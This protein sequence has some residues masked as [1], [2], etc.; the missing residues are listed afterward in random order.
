MRVATLRPG[1]D[2]TH[3]MT[4]EDIEH[5]DAHIG[6][7]ARGDA[8]EALW[9]LQQTLQVEGSLTPHKLHELVMLGDKAPGWMYSRWCVEQAYRWM[10]V[11]RDP[12]TDDAVIH[13]MVAAHAERSE[14][15][16]HD[17]TLFRE[18]GTLIAATDWLCEELAVFDYGGLLDFLD[19]KADASLV[20]RCDQIR[21]WAETRMNGY[22]LEDANG[23]ALRVRDLSTGAP[24][25]VMNIGALTDRGPDCPVIGRVVPVAS[26]PGLMFASR[27]VSVDL[28]TA[29]AVA[30]ASTH[31]DSA[32]WITCIDEGRADGRLE[33][34]FSCRN[35][36]L[37]SSDIVPMSSLREGQEERAGSA[38]WAAGGALGPGAERDPGQRRDGGG[39]RIHRHH[40]EWGPWG[41]HGCPACGGGDS[42]PAGLRGPA[43]ALHVRRA[44]GSLVGARGLLGASPS[45]RDA[46][47]WPGWL[48]PRRGRPSLWSV[49]DG[50]RR[51]GLESNVCSNS[52]AMRCRPWTM[53][54]AAPSRCPGSAKGRTTLA[55]IDLIRA[56]EELKCSA[57]AAQ[58]MLTAAFDRSQ[59]EAEARAGVPA[60]RQ[61]RAVAAQVALAR[62]ESPHRG[63]QH[64]G[65]AVRAR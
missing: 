54:A 46:T 44:C 19:V 30:A 37:F 4:D 12:R 7:A 59:R 55:R 49:A 34:G 21:D 24:L 63:R 62:R 14:E 3:L 8:H 38:T 31:E 22:V 29:Q 20:E 16:A 65:L 9:H 58:A 52:G 35:G 36:T 60:E 47:S 27:P 2:M 13:T 40:R 15:V 45:G 18:L 33:Y 53:S 39:G 57:E 42:R 32:Y 23:S 56:L 41:Q 17:A 64:V 61:G 6:A 25:E 26:A 1:Q 48:P 43:R 28:E 11:E 51:D 5:M 10:L 50:C